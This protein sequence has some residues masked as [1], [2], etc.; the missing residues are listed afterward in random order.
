MAA[1]HGFVENTTFGTYYHPRENLSVSVSDGACSM[2]FA[3]DAGP[4]E[5]GQALIALETPETSIL[6]P[7]PITV[8]G[9]EYYSARVNPLT[10]GK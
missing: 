6:Y 5:V 8:N 4:I 1:R 9:N 7:G 10:S 2:V 3:S